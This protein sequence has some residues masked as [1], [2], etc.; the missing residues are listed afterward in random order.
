M[1]LQEVKFSGAWSSCENKLQVLEQ[2]KE[3]FGRA[4]MAKGSGTATWSD[5]YYIRVH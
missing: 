5:A 3:R 1:L 2:E 4:H